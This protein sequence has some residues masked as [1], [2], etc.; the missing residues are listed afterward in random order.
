MS[1]L[2]RLLGGETEAN[3][4]LAEV[5]KNGALLVD[6]RSKPEYQS[7]SVKGAKN[8]PL[9]SIVQR[10]DEFKGKDHIVVFCRSGNR[11]AQAKRILESKGMN[12]VINGGT[13]QEVNTAVNN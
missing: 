13:W 3:E 2:T 7:G 6:V 9:E 1:F 8:I 11:S 12:N 4:N 5:V 10:L